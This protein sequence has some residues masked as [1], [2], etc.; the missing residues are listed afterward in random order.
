MKKTDEQLDEI[1]QWLE[2]A[3]LNEIKGIC[4]RELAPVAMTLT[5]YERA[6]RFVQAACDR[7][8]ISAKY[9][10]PLMEFA[11]QAKTR[12]KKFRISH[13]ATAKTLIISRQNW[14]AYT[15]G[16]TLR[17]ANNAAAKLEIPANCTDPAIY[18]SS[19]YDVKVVRYDPDIH[20][21]TANLRRMIGVESKPR[22]IAELTE[23][24]PYLSL[25]ALKKKYACSK[26]E[27]EA[28]RGYLEGTLGWGRIW[29]KGE[30]YVLPKNSPIRTQLQ[31]KYFL[32]DNL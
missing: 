10:L 18:V 11:P 23:P 2:T 32:S 5:Q 29:L 26:A 6:T 31:L 12:K 15:E 7:L 30:R 3:T 21:Y 24:K 4:R 14:A 9:L 25:G 13:S 19:E 28:F 22:L 27:I 16:G 1:L 17:R 20:W 8:G